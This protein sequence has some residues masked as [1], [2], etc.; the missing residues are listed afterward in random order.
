MVGFLRTAVV[1]LGACAWTAFGAGNSLSLNGSWEFAFVE[2]GCVTNVA[3]RD[4]A[5]TDRMTVPGCYDAMPKWFLKR[6]TGLYRRTFSLP[7]AV[8]NAWLVV[9]GMGLTANFQ[10]DGRDLG[11]WAYPYRRL[12]IP[13]GPLAAGEH[14]LFAA[15]DN[16]FDPGLQ[17]LALPFYDFYLYGGFYHGVEL[18]FDNRRL[19]VRT[20]DC[21]TGTVEIEAVGFAGRELA[22]PLVFDGTNAVKAVFRG[23]RATVRVPNFRLW[24]PA[25]PGLH[26]VALAGCR[27]RFGIRTVEAKKGA[28]F[29]NGER[30]YLKGVNRHEAH[31]SAGAATDEALMLADIQRIKSLGCN[32]VRGCHYQQAPRFLDLCDETGL[33]VWEESLGWG[34]GGHGE[35]DD[36]KF[37]DDQ[38]AQTKAMVRAS[39]NHPSVVIAAFMNEFG[40]PDPRG[41]RLADR[42]IE[43]IR[44]EDSGRLVTF[45]CNYWQDDI[46][47][48]HT[49]LVAFNVYPGWIETD[50]GDPAQLRRTISNEVARVVERFR[51]QYP[52]KPIIVSEMGTCGEYGRRDP[53]GAQWT[54]D[55]QAEYL[56]DVIDAVFARPEICGLTLWQFADARSYHRGGATVRVKPF[57]ENLAGLYD[58]YRREKLAVPL[59]RAR[60][61]ATEAK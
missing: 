12:E 61:T 49:D 20:R 36:P 29:L 43:A 52:D 33:L 44:A 40:S 22:E 8:D 13:T 60:F 9:D 6:G 17:R 25:S 55:F 45:A 57:A 35:F 28:L 11:L 10:L 23:G 18:A 58:G 37:A 1:A 51:A 3:R 15:L 26:T 42:L 4:F 54:E 7:A 21:A 39:F 50:P 30:L 38:L 27:E 2:N 31:P 5:A 48:E 46:S 47:N 56:A 59:V 34:N 41:K 32:F 24:S 16:R 19:L 14:E 53:A